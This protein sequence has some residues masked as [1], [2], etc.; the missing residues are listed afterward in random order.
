M[1]LN[2]CRN[3]YIAVSENL[4]LQNLET[5]FKVSSPLAVPKFETHPHSEMLNPTSPSKGPASAMPALMD[6]P[7]PK[8][9]AFD[10]SQAKWVYFGMEGLHRGQ[11]QLLKPSMIL[12]SRLC[13]QHFSIYTLSLW[14][15]RL[16]LWLMNQL[17]LLPHRLTWRLQALSTSSPLRRPRTRQIIVS[18]KRYQIFVWYSSWYICNIPTDFFIK[19]TCMDISI[20]I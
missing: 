3:T 8:S 20:Y 15:L 14:R 4:G 12:N 19:Y 7:Q 1:Y 18:S 17:F 9:A 2:D 16:S 13:A 6:K 11:L 5:F 10:P